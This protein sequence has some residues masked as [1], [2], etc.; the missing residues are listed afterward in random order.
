[1]SQAVMKEAELIICC[2]S[3]HYFRLEHG[4][5]AEE[6]YGHLEMLETAD[7]P[8]CKMRSPQELEE[9]SA[10]CDC[11]LGFDATTCKLGCVYWG[12]VAMAEVSVPGLIYEKD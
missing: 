7:C 1:M 11:R 3:L 4:S 9:L 2:S 10:M 6:C 12:S 8:V 5:R